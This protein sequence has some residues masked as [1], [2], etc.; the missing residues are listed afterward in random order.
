MRVES[1]TE[2]SPFLDP[3]NVLA[4]ESERRK[5]TAVL[6]GLGEIIVLGLEEKPQ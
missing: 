2:V 5:L 6:L 3:V 4:L 1:Y